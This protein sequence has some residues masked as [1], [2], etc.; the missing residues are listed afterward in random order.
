M[1]VI[2]PCE[3]VV[4]DRVEDAVAAVEWCGRVV[5]DVPVDLLPPGA[6][7]GTVLRVRFESSSIPASSARGVRTAAWERRRGRTGPRENRT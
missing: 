2:D 6:A 7:E 1:T 4:V 3:Q 5:S